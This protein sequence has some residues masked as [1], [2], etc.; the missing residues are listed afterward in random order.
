MSKKGKFMQVPPPVESNPT[1]ITGVDGWDYVSKEDYAEL[2]KRYLATHADLQEVIET[3]NEVLSRNKELF[4]EIMELRKVHK[5][6]N[7]FRQLMYG[8]MP[9]PKKG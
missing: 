8:G 5:V 4:G 6:V 3:H 9:I 2:E 7:D 1:T